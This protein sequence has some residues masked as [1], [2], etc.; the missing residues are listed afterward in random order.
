ME[1]QKLRS[2]PWLDLS[3]RN[4][5][6]LGSEKDRKM[7]IRYSIDGLLKT[8]LKFHTRL[9]INFSSN[10]SAPI[11][12][13]D[14]DKNYTEPYRRMDKQSKTIPQKWMNYGNGSIQMEIIQKQIKSVNLF[15]D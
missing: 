14:G 7:L 3:S 11:K 6:L 2:Y 15:K 9:L 4:R 1:Q 10:F 13:T 5:P 12:S 8:P